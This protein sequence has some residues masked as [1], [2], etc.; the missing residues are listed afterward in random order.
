VLKTLPP[1]SAATL[2]FKKPGFHDAV[3]KLVVPG[4]GKETTLIQPLAVSQELARV[5]LT[6]DPP[7]AQV[8]KNGELVPG[9]VTPC[10]LLVEADKP[11]QFMLTMPHKIPAV[12]EP[13]RAARGADNIERSGKLVDGTTLHL[14]TN[15]EARF[16]VSGA[17]H[18]ADLAATPAAP[19]EC[20]VAPG[21]HTVDLIVAQAPRITRAVTVKQKDLDV[22]FEVGYVEAAA[23][24]LVQ[25][26]QGAAA[27]RAAFETGTRRVTITGGEEGPHQTTVTIRAGA[28]T[29][30][31]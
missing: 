10:E 15:V 26:G 19:V 2:T 16:R 12:L 17:P 18:C 29:T 27:R 20:V 4:P 13:V 31:N 5:R 1:G 24:R 28:T 22:R 3:A 9:A 23:G 7:G 11:T 6:S 30:V 8:V 21:Q 25:I 14:R